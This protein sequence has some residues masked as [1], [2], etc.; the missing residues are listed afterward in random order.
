MCEKIWLYQLLYDKYFCISLIWCFS[1]LKLVLKDGLRDYMEPAETLLHYRYYLYAKSAKK[2][3]TKKHYYKETLQLSKRGIWKYQL[4]T[5]P[6]E[7]HSYQVDGLENASNGLFSKFGVYTSHLQ[8]CISTT[9][10]YEDRST[11]KR[12]YLKLIDASK[13]FGCVLF[14][15]FLLK[16]KSLVLWHNRVKWTSLKLLIN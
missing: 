6:N 3:W 1:N 9:T 8:H 4:R 2:Q 16:W 13:L 10:N 7:G 14:L 12:K 15:S 5:A 11:A